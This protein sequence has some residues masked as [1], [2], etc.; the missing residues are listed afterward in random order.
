MP[1]NQG[2]TVSNN[3]TVTTGGSFSGP[4]TLS[5]AG[6]PAAVS[7]S[8]SQSTFTPA[9]S[10][11]TT[12][13]TLTYQV[14]P[15]LSPNWYTYTVTAAGDGLSVTWTYTLI[16][17]QA[18][19][20]TAA[21]N[22]TSFSMNSMGTASLNVIATPTGGLSTTSALT[23]VQ[24]VSGLPAGVTVSYGTPVVASSGAV[25]YPLT[26]AGSTAALASKGTLGLSV[27]MT[28]KT[29]GLTYSAS[30]SSTLSVSYVAPTLTLS[31]A[32]T[33]VTTGQGG[34]VANVFSVVTGGSFH[35]PVTLSLSG[36][37][38]TVTA[39]WTSSS[40]TPA[41]AVSTT[42]SVLTLAASPTL[43]P[44]W[45]NFSVTAA[46]DG[47]SVTWNYTLIVN[48]SPGITAAVSMTSFGMT[49][50]GS[51]TLNVIA[52]PFGGMSPSAA[53]TQVSIASGLPAGISVSYGTPTASSSG[54]VTTPVTFTGSTAA[55]GSTD[56]LTF[57]VAATDKNTGVTYTSTTSSSLKVSF[58]SPTLTL[59][60]ASTKLVVVQSNSIN[61]TFTVATGGS[62]H[63]PVTL[64]VSGLP[65]GV[66]GSLSTTGF[67]PA[68]PVSSTSSTLT[69]SV[70]SSV[71]PN[72]YTYSVA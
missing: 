21:V 57:S 20:L 34:S 26:F 8:W 22:M 46:G 48:Q 18:P 43:A 25:T 44:N 27:S 68:S 45:Y 11:S 56:V 29:S 9:T 54:V 39:S 55:L 49:S 13:S 41:T 64:S 58:V 24:V 10:A 69:L 51:A 42:N 12:T 31:A 66:T 16:V 5:V 4:V 36:L 62:F 70:G 67:T 59:N 14:A 35:G 23:S 33:K 32:S 28:D 1:A 7:T 71:P 47:L 50:M 63:G 30:T 40:F 19:G 52:N 38:S 61:N 65:S 53:G 3:F 17:S 60:A 72:W 15:T 2:Q 6:L 37:P